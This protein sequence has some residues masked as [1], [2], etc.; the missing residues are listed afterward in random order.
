[1]T[2]SMLG[3]PEER[4]RDPDEARPCLL[5]A[6]AEGTRV[7]I[8]PGSV[9]DSPVLE[10]ADAILVL[11]EHFD[12]FSESRGGAALSRNASLQV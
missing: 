11:H 8:D 4:N 6:A 10:T 2:P 1:M 3:R 7:V 12:R 5:A 9:W